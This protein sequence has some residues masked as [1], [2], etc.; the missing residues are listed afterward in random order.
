VAEHQAIS[1]V[2]DLPRRRVGPEHEQVADGHEDGLH[3]EQS[4]KK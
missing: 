3:D 1:F 4:R 2:A